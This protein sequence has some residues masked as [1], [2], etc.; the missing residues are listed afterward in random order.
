MEDKKL[1]QQVQRFPVLYGC[2]LNS[3]KDNS[4]KDKAWQN[5]SGVITSMSGEWI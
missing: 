2:S 3:Y 5:I 4:K 1:I